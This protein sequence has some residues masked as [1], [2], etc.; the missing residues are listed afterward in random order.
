MLAL[1]SSKFY[2]GFTFRI[3]CLFSVYE[4]IDI[5]IDKHRFGTNFAE[6][7]RLFTLLYKTHFFITEIFPSCLA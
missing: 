7:G 1:L 5:N 2:V 4:V 6:L 3:F